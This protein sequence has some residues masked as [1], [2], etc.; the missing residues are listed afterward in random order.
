[1]LDLLDLQFQLSWSKV[2]GCWP[3]GITAILVQR[4]C[5][6]ATPTCESIHIERW[7]PGFSDQYKIPALS[8]LF[9]WPH[10]LGLHLL[11][12]ISTYQHKYVV[13]SGLTFNWQILSLHITASTVH[14]WQD[15]TQ[16][17]LMQSETFDVWHT[18]I[19]IAVLML[20]NNVPF[21]IL[22]HVVLNEV[23]PVSWIF[24]LSSIYFS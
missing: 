16:L 22:V 20:N 8:M 3:V 12:A 10:L 24:F 23:Y 13:A 5:L 14:I 18:F 19:F 1:M 6:Q 2:L 15:L 9:L 21:C 4:K 17:Q 11:N 7:F